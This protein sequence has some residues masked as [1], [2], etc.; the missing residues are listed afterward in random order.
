MQI[1]KKIILF[2]GE[3]KGGKGHHY[4]HLVE[5]SFYYKNR[6]EIIW[7]VNKKFKMENL[8]IPDFV[9][10]LNIID[11]ADRKIV[12]K[13]LK[14]I[15]EILY[16][17]IKNFFKSYFFLL[18]KIKFNKKFYKFILN[19]FFLFPKYFS[20]FYEIYDELNLTI[21]DKIIFQ[22]SRINDFELANALTLLNCKSQIHLRIIQLHRKKKLQ[23][24][25]DII[26]RFSDNKKL[27]NSVFV[28]T[29]TDFQKQEIKKL[30]NIEVDLFFNNLSFS[31]KNEKKN[32]LTIGIL[33]ESRFDKG[34]YKTPELIKNLNNQISNKID[35]IIQINNCPPNLNKT[36]HELKELAKEFNNVKLINGY[37]NFF[38]YRE[39]LKKIDII[40]LLH[41][42]DQLKNCGSGIVFS[43]MVNEIPMVIPKNARFVRSFFKYDS[44]LE[45]ESIDDYSKSIEKIIDNYPKFLEM[46]KKQSKLYLNKL[47]HDFLNNRI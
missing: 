18:F 43:S 16:L 5:N 42:L 31:K 10:V 28:Y 3:L 9:K 36:K 35:F 17:S 47:N 4:D 37:I 40:P 19:N 21:N 14:S 46:A 27:F 11:T 2:E 24:F 23:K 38:E 6:G 26:K 15:I 1:R 12:I 33:G 22:T 29:E 44:F 34:F 39:I 20:S 8:F 30:T 25:K 45:A 13:N 32:K 41:E 7:I